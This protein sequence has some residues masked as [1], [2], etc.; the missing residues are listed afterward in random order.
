MD[1]LLSTHQIGPMS[2]AFTQTSFYVISAARSW[3]GSR[4][5]RAGSVGE[6]FRKLFREC[7]EHDVTKAELV[8]TQWGSDSSWMNSLIWAPMAAAGC[9]CRQV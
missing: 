7:S 8:N 5:C 3:I 9:Q 2:Q 4:L 1:G 6:H